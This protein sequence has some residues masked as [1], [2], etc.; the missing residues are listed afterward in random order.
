MKGDAVTQTL[1][2]LPVKGGLPI[3]GGV[4]DIL[5]PSGLLDPTILGSKLLYFL[6]LAV[7]VALLLVLT[8][9]FSARLLRAQ[10]VTVS[11]CLLALL[12]LGFCRLISSMAMP[13]NMPVLR[14]LVVLIAMA[15]AFTAIFETTFI[16]AIAIVLL[17]SILLDVVFTAWLWVLLP[18]LRVLL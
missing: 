16:R 12:C 6:S 15:A 10:R 1:A 11:R 9:Y 17:P 3:W 14:S 2:N 13:S 5:Q 8:F 7:V 18:S 4:A